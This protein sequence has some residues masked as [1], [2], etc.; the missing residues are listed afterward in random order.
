MIKDA[1]CPSGGSP[2]LRTVSVPGT[3][4]MAGF[5]ATGRKVFQTGANAT[6][7]G[8]HG[9]GRTLVAVVIHLRLGYGRMVRGT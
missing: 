5:I 3:I 7:P 6:S 8:E 4:F 1:F 9:T 2:F